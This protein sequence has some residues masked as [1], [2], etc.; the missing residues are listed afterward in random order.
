MKIHSID[1]VRRNHSIEHATVTLLLERGAGAPMGG[2]SIPPGF[3]I[4][5]RATLDDVSLAAQDAMDLLKA[6]HSDLAI[7]PYCG[8]N[9]AAYAVVGGLTAKLVIGRRKGFWAVAG[10]VAT[11]LIAAA[12][13]GKP[14]GR[15]FQSHFTTLPDV[16]GAELMGIRQILKSPVLVVWF[17]T[18]YPRN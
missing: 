5:S 7:S 9:I 14:L 17:G 11:A 18:K 12:L 6:G 2:Y 10:G 15:F 1:D 8:T 3:V 4:W 13:L 16:S